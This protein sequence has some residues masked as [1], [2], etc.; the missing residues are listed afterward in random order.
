MGQGSDQYAV[1]YRLASV[2]RETPYFDL[3]TYIQ[4]KQKETERSDEYAMFCR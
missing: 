3:S 4:G 2:V 1:F